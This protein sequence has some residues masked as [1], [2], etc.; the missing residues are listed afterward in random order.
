[1]KKDLYEEEKVTFEIYFSC[2]NLKYKNNI[3]PKIN[4]ML[5]LKTIINQEEFLDEKKTE[6]IKNN[7]NPDFV[8][9]FKLE[10]IIE[11]KRKYKIEILHMK[12]EEKGDIIGEAFF[13]IDNLLSAIDNVKIINLKNKKERIGK[14]ILHHER[15]DFKNNYDFDLFF[16][17]SNK[18]KS[19]FYNKKCFLKIYKLWLQKKDIKN[20]INGNLDIENFRLSSWIMVLKT[21]ISRGEDIDFNKLS[22][23]S[24]KLCNNFF[25]LPLK[26]EFWQ[27]NNSGKHKLK[28][29]FKTNISQLM[30][31][32]K[33][34]YFFKDILTN[35]K[36]EN[37]FYLKNINSQKKFFFKDYLKEDLKINLMLGIDF[38]IS[39]EEPIFEHSLHYLNG[40]E[41]NPYQES[42]YNIAKVLHS[43]CTNKIYAFGFG[44]KLKVNEISHFFPINFNKEKPYVE[45]FQILNKE[46][47]NC[48]KSILFSGPSFLSPICKKIL[49][50]SK[51]N[52]QKNV[53]NYTVFLIFTDGV[54]NDF[55][56][57]VDIIIES[58]YYPISI[59][60]IGI[61][62]NDFE[63]ME[64]LDADNEDLFSSN[65]ERMIRD[66]VQFIPISK[67][68]GKFEIIK[69]EVLK[70]IP[71]QV[72]RFYSLNGIKPGDKI[73]RD[74][75]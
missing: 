75:F 29:Y 36:T 53:F 60:I 74:F 67:Y 38:S 51:K 3:K 52:F 40:S 7:N 44:A 8:K 6:I 55:Q 17:I 73:N 35:K 22:V 48:C 50:F 45:N 61:G 72:E 9:S 23:S 62:D 42:I 31:N 58:C 28:G 10:F 54:I 5:I 69:E 56:K 34:K 21:N 59:V 13:E 68:L 20:I 1:M 19:F 41:L 70:E 65:G 30:K 37:E 16:S 47:I 57:T 26:I 4:P 32:I 2:R 66:I 14:C 71:K 43:Y 64:M 18:E 27:Y 25:K 46:Y 11:K 24:S 15:V 39:N 12:T 49:D 33:K 63:N